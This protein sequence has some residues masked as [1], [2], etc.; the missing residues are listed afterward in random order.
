MVRDGTSTMI[1]ASFCAEVTDSPQREFSA[2]IIIQE[3]AARK[4]SPLATKNDLFSPKQA[5]GSS[6]KSSRCGY[7]DRVRN[8]DFRELPPGIIVT[9]RTVS[10]SLTSGIGSSLTYRAFCGRSFI[11]ALIFVNELV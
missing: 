4:T 8:E 1:E 11:T 10:L 6:N 5:R 9:V 2:G 3:T 7:H